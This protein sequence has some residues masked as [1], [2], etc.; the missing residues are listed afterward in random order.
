MRLQCRPNKWHEPNTKKASSKFNRMCFWTIVLVNRL[1]MEM[2]DCI[3]AIIWMI[4]SAVFRFTFFL[5]ANLLCAWYFNGQTLIGIQPLHLFNFVA[6][7]E[8]GSEKKKRNGN[9]NS[10][11]LTT[12]K[13]TKNG[14]G[15]ST[16]N[17]HNFLF[18][19]VSLSRI[20]H[21]HARILYILWFNLKFNTLAKRSLVPSQKFVLYAVAIPTG[22]YHWITYN[23]F[24]FLLYFVCPC[25]YRWH[26]STVAAIA[27][28]FARDASLLGH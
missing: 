5:H 12:Q 7:I 28:P 17:G 24:L 26:R 19:C 25:C 21:L 18:F 2:C 22:L 13:Q 9:G 14:L 27:Q 8:I 1:R 11:K 6:V 16:L 20:T 10:K 23:L 15:Q 4:F 3:S